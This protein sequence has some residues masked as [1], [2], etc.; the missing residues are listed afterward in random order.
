MEIHALSTIDASGP[1]YLSNQLNNQY[2]V[3]IRLE[4]TP[5]FDGSGLSSILSEAEGKFCMSQSKSFSFHLFSLSER[6]GIELINQ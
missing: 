1:L 5:F 3:L 2:R 4:R 6:Q